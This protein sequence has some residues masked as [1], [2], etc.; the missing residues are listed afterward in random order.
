MWH[1]DH[2]NRKSFFFKGFIFVIILVA[3]VSLIL[4][5]LWNWLMPVIFGLTEITYWQAVGLLLLSK[6]LFTGLHKKSHPPN[7]SKEYWRKRFEECDTNTD[8]KLNNINC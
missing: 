7:M 8:E 3:L 2:R 1:H 5:L 4:Q 6:I